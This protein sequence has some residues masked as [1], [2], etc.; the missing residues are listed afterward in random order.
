MHRL[1]E[2]LG[3][4]DEDHGFR[5]LRDRQHVGERHLR[6]L[7]HEQ[8]IHHLKDFRRSLQPRCPCTDHSGVSQR[9]EQVLIAFSE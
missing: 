8:H 7:I 9:R 6:R 2:L 4:A 5:C 1:V 3:I